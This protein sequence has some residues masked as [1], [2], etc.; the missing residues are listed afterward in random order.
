MKKSVKTVVADIY[1]IKFAAVFIYHISHFF[2][3]NALSD[4]TFWYPPLYNLTNSI[5]VSIIFR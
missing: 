2:F 1:F 4:K 5:Y 3:Y